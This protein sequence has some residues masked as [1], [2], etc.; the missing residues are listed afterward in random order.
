MSDSFIRNPQ[1]EGDAFF[2]QA[3]KTGALLIHG[4]TASAAE[5]RLLGQYLHARGYT[6]SA[7]LLPG[8]NTF[9]ADLNRQRWTDWTRAAEQAYKNSKQNVIAFSFAANR[10][11][12]CSRS[13]W[14]ANTRKLPASSCPRR[15]WRR[16]SRCDDAS[17]AVAPSICG[18]SEKAGARTERGGC[19][20]ARVHG[21]L[22]AGVGADG[23]FAERG[24]KTVAID[25]T[26]GADRARSA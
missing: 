22:R 24:A 12:G 17:G 6:I 14:R 18:G 15:R 23:E 5:V 26:A 10:W 13:T 20:L 19:K 16:K 4:Y 7:P 9:P 21:Q 8:H 11:A 2:W 25:S 3:G 1:L